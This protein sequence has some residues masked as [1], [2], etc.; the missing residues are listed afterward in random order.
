MP[1]SIPTYDSTRTLPAAPNS[2]PSV[3]QTAAPTAD[4]LGGNARTPT[5]YVGAGMQH[6]GRDFMEVG[7]RMQEKEDADAVMR[8]EVLLKDRA[9]EAQTDWGSRRGVNA[10]GVTQE[11]GEWYYREG[12][13]IAGTLNDRQKRVFGQTLERMRAQS[14]DSVSRHEV[15][16]RNT[17]LAESAEASIVGSIMFAVENSDVP[18]APG[19][20]GAEIDNR[21]SMLA[22]SLGWSPERTH[23]ER[24]KYQ[25]QLHGQI[26][27]RLMV[28]NPDA[29]EEYL[30][31]NEGN[32][33]PTV[34]SKLRKGVE[35]STSVR[36]AQSFAD[37]VM[38]AG[39]SEA[40]A[41]AKAR[42]DL[43][44]DDEVRAVSEI[45]TRFAEQAAA[46]ERAQ[47][48]AADAAYQ[49]YAQ[50]GSINAI[51][52][53][54]WASM[55]GRDQINLRNF[56]DQRIE[57]ANARRSND[58][59]RKAAIEEQERVTYARLA[60]KL[61]EDPKG[62]ADVDLVAEGAGLSDSQYKYFA[63]KQASIRAGVYVEGPVDQAT[64]RAYKEIGIDGTSKDARKAQAAFLQAMQKVEADFTA[65]N[66]RAP[67]A[68]E[69][70]ELVDGLIVE[71]T[72]ED[73]GWLYFDKSGRR[74][75][76][77]AKGQKFTP[78]ERPKQSAPVAV[79]SRAEVEALPKGTRFRYGGKTYVR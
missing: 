46:R 49:H 38:A 15:N 32:I 7:L 28:D 56:H 14:L 13:K 64:K 31:R 20:A 57:R 79:T 68:K 43:S 75:E 23:I 50:S 55:D 48:A 33:D 11:A 30:K 26:I 9:R 29:A 66:G 17:A 47:K 34:V 65:K 53:D 70:A 16:E 77:E 24:V 60:D 25:T 73:G 76:A 78:N 1:I 18:E 61:A 58:P 44:G 22:Q 3:R 39:M 5:D 10:K 8:A 19:I 21:V 74:Y 71:G 54:V 67:T 12:S 59:A 37:G 40:D 35:A 69:K 2:L 52:P 42:A 4:Q 62:F 36:R 41:I 6:A 27:N 72:V 63:D 45:K 51:P